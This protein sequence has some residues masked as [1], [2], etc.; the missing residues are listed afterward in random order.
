MSNINRPTLV[1]NCAWEPV[2]VIAARRAM[3][4]LAKGAAVVQEPSKEFIHTSSMR[5]P[6]P[7]VIRLLSY[8]NVPRGAKAVSR[9]SILMR[10]G[11]R[12]QYC[13]KQFTA[14]ELTLD[15]VNPKSRKGANS[16]ENLVAACI[17]C[18]NRKQDRTPEEAGMPLLKKPSKFGIHAKHRMMASATDEALWGRYLYV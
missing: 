5:F 12:C 17:K 11:N 15:H 6:L 7:S 10:D 14:S 3:T 13:G 4:L 18:N 16:W 9:K 2:H 8:H 1:L